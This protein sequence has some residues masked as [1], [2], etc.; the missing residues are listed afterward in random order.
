M[1]K[2]RLLT[3]V[4]VLLLIAGA[5][6]CSPEETAPTGVASDSE[7]PV[8]RVDV[9]RRRWSVPDRSPGGE[10]YGED[11]RG[12]LERALSV[13]PDGYVPR[14]HHLKNDDSPEYTNRLIQETSPYLLQHAHNPVNWHPWGPE[15]FETAR[16]L[17]RPVLLSVGYSTCHWCHV[18]ERESFEDLEI[19]TY[20]NEHFVPIKVD[21]EERPD[22]DG[23]YMEAVRMLTGRGGWPMTVVMT[24]DKE[25]FFGGTYFPARDGDRGARMGFQTILQR[26]THQY[27]TDRPALIEQ[28][29]ATTKKLQ[30]ASASRPPGDIAGSDVLDATMLSLSRSFDSV[31]GGFGRAP[32]FPRSVTLEF[33]LRYYRRTNN[34][35]ALHMATYTLDRMAAGGM[36]DHVGGG[37]HRYSTDTRWLVPHFEKMLYDNALLAVAYM[38]AFQIT[39]RADFAA[40]ARE[41]LDY[42]A[43]EM[44][45]A[46][47]GFHSATDADSPSESGHEEEGLFFTWTPQEIDELLEERSAA[48]VRAYFK[49]EEGGNFEGRSIL[50]TPASLDRVAKQ[51]GLDVSKAEE[52]IA[53]AKVALYEA[54]LR[55]LPPGKDDKILAAW[56]GLMISAFA[57]GAIVLGD[58]SYADLAKTAASFVLTNMRDDDGRLLRSWHSGDARHAG[59]LDDYAFMIAGLLDVFESTAEPRWLAEAIRLQAV[60]DERF[61]DENGGYFFN[62]DDAEALL[63]RQKPDYDGAIPSGNSFEILNLL[64]LYEF[65]FDEGYLEYAENALKSFSETLTRRAGA[66]PKMLA[67]L[68]FYLD[69]PKEIVLVAPADETDVSRFVE[70]MAD[71]FLPNKIFVVVA[72]GQHSDAVTR[73]VP[74]AADKRPLDEL[75][76]AYVCEN[77]VCKRPTNDPDVFDRQISSVASFRDRDEEEV[78]DTVE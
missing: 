76:T 55:R 57:R 73:L 53:E 71:T 52:M 39:G 67:A 3:G 42:V 49:V 40:I 78:E 31:F 33:L 38:E 1:M 14:T 2:P 58:P 43:R 54:R 61:A 15:A 22:V 32:K 59:V 45:D 5:V 51:Q 18:M 36:R 8:E 16:R 62:A 12:H 4:S 46:A 74:I 27:S 11:L 56:N 41:T 60:V 44:T 6:A 68:D 17:D 70:R 72:D 66:V 26:L 21:R 23:V 29:K 77:R 50:H 19:A 24:P 65:T 75:T 48:L 47:G 13:K 69:S 35:E 63:V 25:V 34:P 64:R 7:A 9:V 37:F 20:I 28:A 30:A 10:L